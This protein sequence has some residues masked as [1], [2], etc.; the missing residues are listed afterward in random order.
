MLLNKIID[1]YT[2]VYIEYLTLTANKNRLD[3]E[4][5]KSKKTIVDTKTKLKNIET[6]F[7]LTSYSFHQEGKFGPIKLI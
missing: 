6:F 2:F 5:E 1:E 7:R 4:T 3:V